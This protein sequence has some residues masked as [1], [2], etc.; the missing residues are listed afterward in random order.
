M[1]TRGSRRDG[2]AAA[3]DLVAAYREAQDKIRNGLPDGTPLSD[4]ALRAQRSAQHTYLRA[5]REIG[6]VGVARR[7]ENG[8]DVLTPPPER[9]ALLPTLSLPRLRGGT[10]EWRVPRRRTEPGCGVPCRWHGGAPITS[11]AS[12]GIARS[13]QG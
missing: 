11:R 1:A 13:R 3:A 12:C 5:L 6:Q 4:A 7:L 8:E 9:V 10:A 2:E